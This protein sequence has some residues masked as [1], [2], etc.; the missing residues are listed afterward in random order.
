MSWIYRAWTRI[1]T[2]IKQGEG[3]FLLKIKRIIVK[4]EN[5]GYFCEMN[6]RSVHILGFIM[7]FLVP[8]LILAQEEV[9][10]ELS[11]KTLLLDENF[12]VKLTIKNTDKAAVSEFPNLINFTK[13]AKQK[14]FS[15]NPLGY[16]IIQNY[17][18]TKEGFFKI[19]AF[20]LI[21]NGK[22]YTSETISVTVN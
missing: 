18:P 13:G 10:I 15:K 8:N 7:F 4:E 12:T 14:V 2:L 22:E 17:S 3:T 11:K 16:T 5:S 21:I 1:I 6:N 9:K 19:P 20:T